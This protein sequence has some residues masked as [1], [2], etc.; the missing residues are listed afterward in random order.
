MD[1]GT[2]RGLI[3]LAILVLFVGLWAW[4]WSRKR[5]PEYDAAAQMPLADDDG[6]PPRKEDEKEHNA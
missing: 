1:I 4:N 2:V 3:T 5:K 6:Q